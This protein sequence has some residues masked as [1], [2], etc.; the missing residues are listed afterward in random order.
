MIIIYYFVYGLLFL[1]SLL[2]MFVLYAL[3]DLLTFLVFRVIGYRKDVVLANLKIAFPEKNAE[4]REKIAKDFYRLFMDTLM[5]TIKLLSLSKRRVMK[6][7]VGSAEILNQVMDKGR[8]LTVMA[9]HNF[10]WEVVNQNVAMQ[11]RYPFVAVYMPISSTITEKLMARIRSRFGTILIPATKFKSQYAQYANV[12]HILALVADQN[13]GNPENANWFPFFGKMTPF[14]KG[15]EKGA[16]QRGDAVVFA[17]FYPVR[18]GVYT[19][20]WKIPTYNAAELEEGELTRMYV[21]YVQECIRKQPA[22]YLWSHRRW[23]HS[24]EMAVALTEAG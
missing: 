10:N 20:D 12:H 9:M 16:R 8:N 19:F 23:K 1:V 13:P 24:R 18:R 17:H 11:L 7:F 22:N 2:P 15:P 21:E 14:V 3:S 4:E 5:E 6:R